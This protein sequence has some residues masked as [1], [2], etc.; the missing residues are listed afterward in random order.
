MNIIK[1]LFILCTIFRS[2]AQYRELIFDNYQNIDEYNV[3]NN[4]ITFTVSQGTGCQWM[5]EY[6]ANAL[7]T[8]N[9]YFTDSVCTYQQ[10]SGCAGNPQ[11]GVTYTCCSV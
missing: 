7:G 6:C 10:G 3:S 9:Y 8:N 11:A 1:G 4:C 2:N 5:C